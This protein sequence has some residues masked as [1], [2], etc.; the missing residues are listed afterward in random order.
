MPVLLRG[1]MYAVCVRWNI[2]AAPPLNPKRID[3]AGSKLPRHPLRGMKKRAADPADDAE[4]SK[5]AQQ[6]LALRKKHCRTKATELE[7]G[8]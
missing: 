4:T 2:R 8:R 6:V 5:L 7:P 3:L 1:A